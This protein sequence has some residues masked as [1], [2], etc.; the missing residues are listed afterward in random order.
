MTQCCCHMAAGIAPACVLSAWCGLQL[1]MVYH[2]VVSNCFTNLVALLVACTS[3]C[4]CSC[5][6]YEQWNRFEMHAA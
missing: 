4:P 6:P 3:L 1:F 2:A 5:Q